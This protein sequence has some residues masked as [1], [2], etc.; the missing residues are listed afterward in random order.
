[1]VRSESFPR[2]WLGFFEIRSIPIPKPFL[3]VHTDGYW[4]NAHIAAP[5]FAE[6]EIQVKTVWDNV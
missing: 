5:N 6:K 2:L 4:A 3:Y 1:M